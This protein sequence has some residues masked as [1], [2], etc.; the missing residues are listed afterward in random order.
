MLSFPN[1]INDNEWTN[2]YTYIGSISHNHYDNTEQYFMID[3]GKRY[4]KND[5]N[6]YEPVFTITKD[7]D[8]AFYGD[9]GVY[10]FDDDG[11]K[12][13]IFEVL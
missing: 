13:P 5:S 6:S 4:H 10:D 3:V 1:K 12:T 8:A 2:G 11:E 7:G 9:F